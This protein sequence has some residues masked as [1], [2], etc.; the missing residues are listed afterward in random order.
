MIDQTNSSTASTAFFRPG[1]RAV[2]S[3]GRIALSTAEQAAPATS[4]TPATYAGVQSVAAVLEEYAQR[5]VFRGFSAGPI[6]RGKAT[7]KIA[8]HRDQVFELIFD[9]AQDAL[10]FPRVLPNVPLG[11]PM[12]KEFKKFVKARQSPDLPDHRRIDRDKA[13]LKTHCRAGNLS[14]TLA[15]LDG[16][17]EYGTRKI[18]ALVHEIYLIFLNDGAWYDYMVEEF[19]ID[20]DTM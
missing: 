15:M 7:F 8:W 1:G 12:H 4:A 11:S 16:D 20:P 6:R 3:E 14:F 10:R 18:I 13:Q 9:P 2:L 19:D 5:G 17:L